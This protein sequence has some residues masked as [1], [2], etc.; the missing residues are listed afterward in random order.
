[1]W[2]HEVGLKILKSDTPSPQ[3]NKF[4]NIYQFERVYQVISK[5]LGLQGNKGESHHPQ[6]D[7]EVVV[8]ILSRR[9]AKQNYKWLYTV[10]QLHF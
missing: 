1:M 10:Y 2:K 8:V 4:I 5:T 9:L 6:M 3:L 7:K